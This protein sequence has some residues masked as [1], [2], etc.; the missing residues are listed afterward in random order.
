MHSDRDIPLRIPTAT[1]HCAFRP[2]HP[3]AHFDRD[4]PLLIPNHLPCSSPSEGETAEAELRYHFGDKVL[5][6]EAQ[7]EAALAKL[8]RFHETQ[9]PEAL[10]DHEYVGGTGR[11]S[12]RPKQR[13]GEGGEE[14]EEKRAAKN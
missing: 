4:I 12:R 2:R 1:S 7:K 9:E 8:K 10:A 3:T 11:K 5:A 14:R 13:E 6:D